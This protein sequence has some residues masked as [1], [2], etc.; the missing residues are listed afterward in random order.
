MNHKG[1]RTRKLLHR[2][3][4]L[5]RVYDNTCSSALTGSPNDIVGY[6]KPTTVSGIAK[7]WNTA[8]SYL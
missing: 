1:S 3:K 6:Q 8:A 4:T 2:K 5:C 7:H